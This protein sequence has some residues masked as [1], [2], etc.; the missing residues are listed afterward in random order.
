MKVSILKPGELKA[1]ISN[2]DKDG[3]VSHNAI[4]L[5][6]TNNVLLRTNGSVLYGLYDSTSTGNFTRE[7]KHVIPFTHDS[8]YPEPYIDHTDFTFKDI[9]LKAYRAAI[10]PEVK[11]KSKE[12][13]AVIS[14]YLNMK[15]KKKEVNIEIIEEKELKKELKVETISQPII[16]TKVNIMTIAHTIRKEL[17]LEGHY[18]VQMKIAMS[19]AWQVK[20]GIISL[21]ELTTPSTVAE[22][23]TYNATADQEAAPSLEKEVSQPNVTRSIY[24]KS[25]IDGVAI[26]AISGFAKPLFSLKARNIRDLDKQFAAKLPSLIEQCPTSMVI[27]CYGDYTRLAY[28]NNLALK[29]IGE[30]KGITIEM[31]IPPSGHVA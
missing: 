30:S 23:N 24:L 4:F 27:K 14:H 8:K 6:K 29:K 1:I 22:A 16:K 25:F 12:V 11:A 15:M 26:F 9:I 31:S 7:N 20:R 10:T 28:T 5:T 19:Y 2:L 3:K 21:E 18:R 17:K 13:R